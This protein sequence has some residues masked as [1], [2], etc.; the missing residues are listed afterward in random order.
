M[1]PPAGF[2]TRP[3]TWEDLE[4]VVALF[5][6]CDAADAGVQDPVREHL[7]ED[8]RQAGSD[9]GS[10][11]LLVDA[12][13]GSLAGY[14]N[15][16]GLNPEL[17]VEGFARVHPRH[18]GRGVGA[19]LVGWTEERAR[20]MAGPTAVLRNAVSATDAAAGGLL[21]A[22][23][24]ALARVFWLMERSLDG[25]EVPP[26][27]P[28]GTTIRGY[29]HQVDADRVYDAV[30]EAFT[31][32]W[33][34]EPYPRDLHMEEMGRWDPELI[35]IALE[36]DE[37]TGVLIARAVEGAGWVDVLGVR[38]PWRGRGIARALL[39]CSFAAFARRGAG[40]VMLS[41]DSANE[42]GATRLYES[43]GMHV[44][45]AWHLFE[46]PADVS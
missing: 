3:A 36:G 14:A 43:A 1:N 40:S 11:T 19:S 31:D 22:R 20:A 39:R 46:R 10:R 15:V 21:A 18:R 34:Y 25:R 33:G 41:V 12:S 6:T 42:T 7:E 9:L 37:V 24:Y 45:R 32:H 27:D 4:D 8:W 26:E 16:V 2:A 38:R 13:D 23:G 30:E 5:K 29:R 28:A 17:S 44:R 35:L